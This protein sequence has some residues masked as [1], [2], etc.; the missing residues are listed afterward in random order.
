M[1]SLRIGLV[2]ADAAGTGWGPTA[3]IPAIA[4]VD[5]VELAAVCTRRP[6]SA[7]AAAEAYGVPGFHDVAAMATRDDIDIQDHDQRQNHESSHSVGRD[8]QCVGDPRQQACQG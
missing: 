8:R 2:G 5:G 3:H 1:P 7:A 6:E 4:A